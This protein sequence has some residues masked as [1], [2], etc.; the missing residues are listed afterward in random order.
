[1][2]LMEKVKKIP[3]FHA[4]STGASSGSG[5]PVEN[6]YRMLPPVREI[7]QANSVFQVGFL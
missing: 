3:V 4:N 6:L 1:M 5:Y 2:L 7:F